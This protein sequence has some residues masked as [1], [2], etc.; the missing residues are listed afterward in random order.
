MDNHFDSLSYYD[1]MKVFSHN[2][3]I[4]SNPD[5]IFLS[6]VPRSGFFE[7]LVL[8]PFCFVGE[9]AEICWGNY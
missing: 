8:N 2:T 3:P 9:I 7:M 4:F 6:P 1:S 5:F